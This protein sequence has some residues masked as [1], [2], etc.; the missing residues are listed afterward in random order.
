MQRRGV[1]ADGDDPSREVAAQAI[2]A[3]CPETDLQ[4]CE[5]WGATDE[6]PVGRVDRRRVHVDEYLV[7]GDLR[8]VDV[9]ELQHLIGRSVCTVDDCLHGILLAMINVRHIGCTAYTATEDPK[10]YVVHCQGGAVMTSSGAAETGRDTVS[11]QRAPLN[12][13]RVLRAAVAFADES[14]IEALSMRMLAQ[15]LGV[16][17]MALYKHVA[18]KGELLDGMVDVVVGEIDP[19]TSDTAW[20]PAIRARILSARRALARHP[21]AYRVFETRAHATPVVLEYIDSLVGMFLAGGLS[22]DLTHHA[23]HLLGG[24]IWGFSQELFPIAA[25]P[26]PDAQEAMMREAAARYPHI[27]TMVEA[28][29]HDPDSVVG[30]GCDDRFEFEF[31][32]DVLFDGIERLHETGWT[33]HDHRRSGSA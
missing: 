22:V 23:M 15:Q 4:S 1:L 8:F 10:V 25:D 27:V 29:M 11:G 5:V 6:V 13:E 31:A 7:A 28:V 18:N 16:V 32:I 20:K 2:D 21:W 33:S 17:P 26:D 24:R 19:P 3:W 12:R 14:G 30:G 9:R